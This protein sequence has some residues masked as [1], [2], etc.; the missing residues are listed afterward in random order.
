MNSFVLLT[1]YYLRAEGL[2]EAEIMGYNVYC[3]RNYKPIGRFH[4]IGGMIRIGV[5]LYLWRKV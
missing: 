4:F 5:S 2:R 3:S 1:D